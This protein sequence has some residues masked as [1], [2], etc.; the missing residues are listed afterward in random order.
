MPIDT[1]KPILADLVKFGRRQSAPRPWLGVVTDE[2][3]GRLIVS[4]V[5][6]ESPA[7]SAG[8]QKGDIILGVGTDPVGSYDDFYRKLW[9]RSSAGDVITLRV[10]Q[11]SEIHEID[12]KSI[13]RDEY[14]RSSRSSRPPR[15]PR[16]PATPM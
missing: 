4:Q 2:I 14:F 13:G 8:V 6:P 3:F 9:T 15:T 12:V 11:G 5:S 16:L 1:L 10:L 7:H